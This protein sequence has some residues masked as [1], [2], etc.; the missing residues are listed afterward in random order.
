MA[1]DYNGYRQQETFTDSTTHVDGTVGWSDQD[2]N[3]ESIRAHE[4]VSAL[5]DC[6][7]CVL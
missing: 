1:A 4:C 2:L 5:T 3:A 7:T 6:V